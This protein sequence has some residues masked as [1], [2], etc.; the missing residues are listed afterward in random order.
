V[1]TSS[2]PPNDARP[3]GPHPVNGSASSVPATLPP[4]LYDEL[5]A[6]G[7]AVTTD[8]D[9][10]A[11][12]CIDW[13]GRWS[14]PALAAVHPRTTEQVTAALVAARSAGVPVQVQ[15]GNTG[16]VGGSVPD[17]PSLLLVT[18]GLDRMD[19]VDILERTV[20]VGAGV[21]AAR[22]AAHAREA[23]LH[24]GVD[25]AARD[26]ATI[27]GMV[28]TNAGGMGVCAYGMMREQV[29]GLKAVLADGRV[30]TTLGRPRKD[31]CGYD[32]TALIAGSEGTIGV[33][34]EV[35]IALHPQPRESSVALLAVPDLAEAVALSRQVQSGQAMLLAAEVV[36]A[37]GVSRAARALG[38]PDPLPE[39][40]PWLLLL[41][42]ADGGTGGGFESVADQVVAVATDPA[43][44]QR[45]WALR[46]RQTEL[47]ATLP[48]L[49]K[50]DV[51]VRLADLDAVV[52]AIRAAATRADPDPGGGTVDAH[53]SQPAASVE[54]HPWVGIFGHAL[55]GNLHVQLVAADGATADRILRA[56]A[57][58]GG[59][60]S[61]EHGIGRLKVDQL[62][63]ARSAE[64]ID[65]MR[66]MKATVDPDGLLN[67]GVL[68][69]PA[70]H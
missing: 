31:N 20:V 54:D 9:L 36:D 16:L 50:L 59:S 25:L 70:P 46:E 58:L 17:R 7:I 28:A 18:T 61:A 6:A 2:Y 48:G 22:L 30:V 27:G 51:S 69:D 44:R 52:P 29:R 63:L 53:S 56:V 37:A 35:E 55:D 68:V 32:L 33:I 24:F 38:Q 26:S 19:P 4:G 15:G 8:P 3:P 43:G 34:T 40:A 12:H 23:G 5:A 10:L 47:Y 60:I 62:H 42:V 45:L 21:T 11:G 64:Q 39:G 57:E 41:E 66:R 1:T 14:G 49:Q 67:P 13:T 65:W